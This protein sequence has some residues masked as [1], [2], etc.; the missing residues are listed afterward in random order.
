MFKVSIPEQKA[1]TFSSWLDIF[2]QFCVH[3]KDEEILEKYSNILEGSDVI[4]GFENFFNGT[5]KC[6]QDVRFILEGSKD[7]KTITCTVEGK[8][9]EGKKDMFKFFVLNKDDLDFLTTDF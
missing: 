8:T 6:L 7:H 5:R 2:D 4:Y 3:V 1:K 9:Q